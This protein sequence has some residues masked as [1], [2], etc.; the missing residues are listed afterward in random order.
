MLL[1]A[2]FFVHDGQQVGEVLALSAKQLGFHR[3]HQATTTGTDTHS[4]DRITGGR[5]QGLGRRGE[6]SASTEKR[7]VG[8]RRGR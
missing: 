3:W 5:H 8:R 7:W 1:N 6:G 4:I 2:F